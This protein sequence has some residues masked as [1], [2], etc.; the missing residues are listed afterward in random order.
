MRNL[1][2]ATSALLITISSST[3][4][5]GN[6]EDYKYKSRSGN[7]YKY[8]LSDR[9]D[10]RAYKRDRSAQRKDSRASN[11]RKIER[12]QGRRQYGGGLQD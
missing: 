5:I 8:D 10:R 3:Y 1:I 11:K 4:A 7:T 9:S 12:D 2:L 6:D